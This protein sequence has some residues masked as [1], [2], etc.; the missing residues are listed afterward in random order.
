MKVA[1]IIVRVLMGILFLI[2]VIGFFFKLMPE[3][4]LNGNAQRFVIGLDASGYLLPLVKVVELLCAVAFLS[5][6]FMPLAIV[7]IFPIS[8]NILLFHG[9]LAPE[10]MIV[11]LFLFIGNLFLAYAY[12]KNYG[13]LMTA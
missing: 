7:I 13:Q 10:G 12:R 3:P 6:R 5:G 8:L 4:E 9:F 11:P 1:V 2:S